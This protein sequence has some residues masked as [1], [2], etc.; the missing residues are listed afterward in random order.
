LLFTLSRLGDFHC[1]DKDTGEVH[2]SKNAAE[3]NE[4]R[5]PGWGFA[6]SPLVV[7]DLILLNIGEAGMAIEKSSGRVKWKSTDKDAGYSSLVPMRF[8]DVDAVVFG[9]SRSYVC[10]ETETGKEL[11]RKRWLTTFGCNAA[12]PIVAD[13]KVFLSSG[14]NRGCVL[15][16]VTEDNLREVWKNKEMQNQISTSLLINDFVYG[17]HGDIDAGTQLRCMDF[18]S[19]K[20]Q[21]TED[22]FHPSALAAAGNRLIAISDQGDLVIAQ[23]S[24]DAVKVLSTHPLMVEKC[25][26]SPVLSGGM[27]YV[28]GVSGELV[29]V[30]LSKKSS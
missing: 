5:V 23:A 11:W 13:G 15:L 29:C 9:S 1:F 24:S 25:W 27:L 8:K 12:D 20:V 21:W 6:G 19:G 2:W 28:R 17:I 18:Q 30:D 7:G 10:V 22:S 16:D 4:I 26:T 14:Y 3:E